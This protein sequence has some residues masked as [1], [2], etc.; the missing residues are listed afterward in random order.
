MKAFKNAVGLETA[1]P[2]TQYAAG[3]AVVTRSSRSVPLRSSPD[4]LAA[5]PS[6]FGGSCV[7]SWRT[8]S[9][10]SAAFTEQLI[11]PLCLSTTA[12]C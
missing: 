11:D 3:E 1:P 9:L 7:F 4:S 12:V 6:R 5:L 10:L 8:A 2:L